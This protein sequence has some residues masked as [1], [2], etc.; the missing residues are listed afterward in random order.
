MQHCDIKV[1]NE[2]S[3]EEML[4]QYVSF[5]AKKNI[6]KDKIQ[7]WLKLIWRWPE[8]NQC[9]TDFAQVISASLPRNE[10]SKSESGSK[11]KSNFSSK[12]CFTLISVLDPRSLKHLIVSNYR[13]KKI[14]W[15]EVNERLSRN[16]F[17]G[18]RFTLWILKER[19]STR[20]SV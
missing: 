2:T 8:L 16:I 18:C 7:R 14:H 3:R 11:L 13:Q 6:Y 9:E 4:H 10:L 19:G 17:S 5:S 20:W 1:E 12:I 15:C